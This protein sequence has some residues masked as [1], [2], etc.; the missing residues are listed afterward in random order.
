MDKSNDS[1]DALSNTSG[2]DPHAGILG[3]VVNAVGIIFALGILVSA[4]ILVLEVF[5]RYVLNKP[6]IWAHET[7]IFLNAIAF[8]FGGLF[9][10]SRNKHIRVVLIYDWIA[11]PTRRIF[12]IWISLTCFAATAF[13]AWAAWQGVKRAVWTPSGDFRLDT[14]GSAWNPPTPG[15]LKVFLLFVLIIMAIQF[16]I[17][18]LSY[19]SRKEH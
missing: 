14:S 15:V 13:F 1:G 10:A 12:D 6:T 7:V 17:F 16:L 3:R 11:A 2:A 8:L 5:L 19:I 4:G 9:V 18:A